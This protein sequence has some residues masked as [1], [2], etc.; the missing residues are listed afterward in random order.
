M[1]D[2]H[3]SFDDLIPSVVNVVFRRYKN[4]VERKD[5]SQEAYAFAA[6]RGA[7]FAGADGMAFSTYDALH[8]DRPPD[9]HAHRYRAHTDV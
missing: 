4:F 8:P 2:L 3:P 5:L 9:C 1:T 7:R 6:Q